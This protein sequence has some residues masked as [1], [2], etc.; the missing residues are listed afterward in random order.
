MKNLIPL[1]LFLL[2]FPMNSNAQ[3]ND[4]PLLAE[5][6]SREL[7]RHRAERISAVRYK[8]RLEL[9]SGAER[10]KGREEI[11]FKLT[12]AGVDLILDFRDLDARGNP[13]NGSVANV[14]INDKAA[15]RM[16]LINGHIVLPGEQFKNG[17]NKI[18]LDFE[19]GAAAAG[20]PIIRYQD[21]DDGGEYLHTLFVP[22][23]AHLTFPCF[24]QPDLKARFT[25]SAVTP[26]EWI[27]VSNTR[28]EGVGE[29]G[30][31]R[32]TQFVETQPI[33]TYLFAFAA[34]PFK[35]LGDDPASTPPLRFLVRRSKFDRAREELPEIDR[36]TRAGMKH[37][38][39]FFGHS[40]PFS[41]YDQ[42]LIPGFAYGGMEHVGA[43]F[44]REDSILFRS[45]PTANDRFSRA[46]LILHELAHQWFGD[47]VTMRWFDDLWLKEGFANYM[48][49]HAMASIY[50][51]DEIWKRFYLAHKP[52][53]YGIDATRGTTPIYQEVRNLKDAK[54]A[55]G[56]IVYQKAP[57][58]LHALSFLIGEDQFRNGVRAFLKQHAYANAEWSDLIGVFEK[59]SNQKL[60]VWANA[61]VKRR[62][63]PQ[64][65]VDWS[66]DPGG[67]ID[68]FELRQHDSLGEGRA[69]P[70]K[71][72]VLLAYDDA[73][74][75]RITV[76]I[77]GARIAAP[78]AVGKKCPAYVFANDRDYGY[79]RF[80]LD[81][82]S[83]A[84]VTT[85][86][87]GIKDSFLRTM[88]WGALWDAVREAEM[89]PA[90]YL[91]LAIALLPA[92]QDESLLQ[93]TLSRASHAWQRY[94]SPSQQAE[95]APRF[96]SFL[97]D[98]MLNSKEQGA[99]ILYF[100]S[101]RSLAS[102]EAGRTRLKEMLSG[103]LT[104]PGVEI[105]P[106]DRWQI[107]TRL[108]AGRDPQAAALL[109]AERKRDATDDGRKQAYMAEA[110]R[111]DAAVKGRYFDDY[112]KNR[113]VPEDWVEGSLVPFNSG[114]Q[115]ALTLPFLKP[116]LEALPQVKRERKIFFVLAWLNNFLGG[117]TSPEALAQVQAFLK[118]TPLDRDLELK[119]LEVMDEL[120]RTVRIR[121]H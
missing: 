103:K 70:I 50:E 120:E 90:E 94:L 117:Q 79:G 47:L 51:P 9:R 84:A 1:F 4:D 26:K 95:V 100:R 63:M 111:A 109:D 67:R 59:A 48:A 64:I 29:F 105:K 6:V 98:R 35:V 110:A 104:I 14:T 74:P 62:G 44:L 85:R 46:S 97:A 60:E 17:E 28:E 83:R 75:E 33:S 66:C 116:A 106:L 23:D 56:A 57:S 69:W 108:I 13:I 12:N 114:N 86:I 52:L 8:L 92:E 41:K 16:R 31:I 107:L 7:A 61:W 43:T 2:G 5:G 18:T 78:E 73:A 91:E 27:V 32:E 3:T 101:Y 36:I 99:R 42:V 87:G 19:T 119:V 34:G 93:S 102:T 112:L 45:T 68:R 11:R 24:D 10:L 88:L 81:A 25:F 54:S 20:R 30:E 55:Y 49:Y 89:K 113:A 76:Q 80:M 38:V 53:A 121:A 39:D 40:F 22:M 71:S 96:E 58:L 65:N 37:M 15:E 118:S 72:R 21:K 82:R 115:S 77:E